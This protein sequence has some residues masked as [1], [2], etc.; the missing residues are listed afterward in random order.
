[1]I[2]MN[3]MDSQE[4]IKRYQTAVVEIFKTPNGKIVLDMLRQVYVDVSVL[5]STS[6]LTHYRLGQKELVQQLIADATSELNM[7][8]ETVNE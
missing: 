5:E 7:T 2:D 1:M 4:F 3:K 6:D 8:E